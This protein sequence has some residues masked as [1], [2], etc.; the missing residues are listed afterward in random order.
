[1]KI[2]LFIFNIVLLFISINAMNAQNKIEINSKEAY[3][4]LQNNTKIVILDVRTPGEF[5]DGH[6]KGAINIDIHQPDA[7]AKI[8]KLDHSKT[9]LVHCR[10]NHRSK[11][12]A[13]HMV[14]SGFKTVYQM[15]DGYMG[16]ASNALPSQ[17]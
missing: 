7:L 10:T 12:A 14:Q 8:D 5:N 17:K 16:W 4:M 15:M 6:L 11:I 3:T 9:Y 13:D 2:K 1:M